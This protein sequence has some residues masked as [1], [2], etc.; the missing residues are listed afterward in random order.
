MLIYNH[1]LNTYTDITD[2]KTKGIDGFY[3]DL[4]LPADMMAYEYSE[5]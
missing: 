4:L 2:G 3:T 1:T 5:A